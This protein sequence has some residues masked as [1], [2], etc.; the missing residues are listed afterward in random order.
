MATDIAANISRPIVNSPDAD[1]EFPRVAL[2]VLL[3]LLALFVGLVMSVSLPLLADEPH[4]IGQIRLF[5]LGKWEI[6][7]SLTTIPGYHAIIAAVAGALGSDD[8]I[9]LRIYSFGL[10][11]FAL[12]TLF[13]LARNAR[14]GRAIERLL[15]MAFLPILFPLFFL[16][17][18]D[19]A[20]ILF[21]SVALLLQDK[22]RYWLAAAAATAS[23]AVR[24][25]YIVWFA[26]AALLLA[27]DVAGAEV[28]V[29]AKGRVQL[30]N[31]NV[32]NRATLG[33]FVR[34]EAGY[35]IGLLVFA[36]FVIWNGGIAVGD[37]AMH[38]FPSLHLGNLYFALFLTFF[39]LL[40]LHV[41]NAHRIAALARQP[42]TMGALAA[43]LLLFLLTFAI[44]HPYNQPEL[45]WW[46]H[47]RLLTVLASSLWTKLA[48][49]GAIAI[50]LL[51][52]I[53]T[54]LRHRSHTLVYPFAVLS[55][56][57]AWQIEQRYYLMPLILFLLFRV[58]RSLMFEWSLIAYL[59]AF[60]A[61]L[62]FGIASGAYFL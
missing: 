46:L 28:A 57:P 4:H 39:L 45:N 56:V 51:S 17:Y 1:E 35:G 27:K 42:V 9:S 60:S 18:T 62:F 29:G 16:L 38:P 26:F 21:F 55:L 12:I 22:S 23:L 37:R 6:L 20:A 7:P 8:V 30:A 11:I 49:F 54:P 47:N 14:D 53:V 13:A 43:I 48:M 52:L 32:F 10:S 19:V 61:I 33:E 2:G 40:P 50:A 58:Q 59:A 25:N 3:L 44:D 36:A 15:Q 34:K 5:M 31:A 24:Q 41:V